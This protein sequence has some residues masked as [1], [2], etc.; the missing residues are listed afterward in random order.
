[1][2]R[3]VFR[4]LRS[5]AL[6]LLL[7][8]VLATAGQTAPPKTPPLPPI[9]PAAAPAAPETT[10]PPYEAQ[11]DRL[12]ELIGTL[13]FMRDLCGADDGAAWHDKM[14]SLL[15]AEAKTS[16]RKERLAGSYNR[17]YQGYKLIYRTCTPSARAVIARS[18]QEG[19]QIASDL[20]IRFGGD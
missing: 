6:A 11:L 9:P 20:S 8:A 12:A 4:G 7:S 13:A 5:I 10:L 14:A 3:T 1:M 19:G 17:G 18:L 15:D 2:G 16:A